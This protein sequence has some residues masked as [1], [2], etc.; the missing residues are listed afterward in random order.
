MFLEWVKYN[1][2]TWKLLLD[3][4]YNHFNIV[5]QFVKIPSL[6]CWLIRSCACWMWTQVPDKTLCLVFCKLFC[7]WNVFLLFFTIRKHFSYET[8]FRKL[9]FVLTEKIFFEPNFCVFFR[10]NIYFRRMVC[11]FYMRIF[12]RFLKGFSCA[13]GFLSC[14]PEG[15]FY[16][17]IYVVFSVETA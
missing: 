11:Y 1:H 8:L 17:L 6:L 3:S 16:S 7:F 15:I 5:K 2:E 9:R 13:N 10:S 14:C 12:V 4:S